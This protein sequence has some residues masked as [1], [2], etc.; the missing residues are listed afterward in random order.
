MRR[1]TRKW[2][3]GGGWP[4]RLEWLE[5][6][7][8]RGWTGQR[9]NFAY[10]IVAIVGE[11][12]SGKSTLLQAAACLY[13]TEDKKE[14]W[15]ASEFFPDTAWDKVRKAEVRFGFREGI[16]GGHEERSIRKPST[17]WL[18][19]V[20]RP[21]RTVEYIDLSR[22]QPVSAR[23]GYAKIAKTRHLEASSHPFERERLTRL[24]EIM[25]RVYTMAKMALTN[26]DDRREIPVIKKGE[27][28]YSGYH[29]GSGETTIVELLKADLPKYGLVLIDEIESSLHPRAQRRLIRDLAEKCREREFQIILTTHSPY[30]LDELPLEARTYILE[31]Q[32]SKQIVTGVSPQFAMTQMDDQQHPECELYV[33]DAAAKVMLSEILA[34]HAKELFTRCFIVPYGAASVGHALGIMAAQNRF[35]RPTCV[36]LDGDNDQAQGC[37]LLPGGDA[38]E[39]VVFE[40]MKVKRW[41]NLWTRLNRDIAWTIDACS[42]AMTLADHHEWVRQAANNLRCSGDTLWQSMCAEWARELKP[43]DVRAVVDA[44]EAVLP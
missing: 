29:Q 37:T 32:N 24:S 16:G 3:G 34:S 19:N 39:R 27:N 26:I 21:K 28:S 11:N 20:D 36:F 17:R 41:G 30:I 1:L 7:G 23:V 15:F 13:L 35:P 4:K 8:L 22:I 6:V 12:G 40:A 42:N 38:P 44:V 10:P 31:T 43:A 33:E 18:G 5:I 25:G 2:G 14:T 9:I